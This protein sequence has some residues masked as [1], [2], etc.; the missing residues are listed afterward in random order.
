[1]LKLFLLKKWQG[2]GQGTDC[3]EDLCQVISSGFVGVG[4]TLNKNFS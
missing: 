2:D 3:I 4:P 1:M